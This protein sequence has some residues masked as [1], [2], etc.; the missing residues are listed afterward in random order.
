[1]YVVRVLYGPGEADKETDRENGNSSTDIPLYPGATVTTKVMLLLL[2]AFV[3]HHK[4]SK[5]VTNDLL[6]IFN[7]VLPKPNNCCIT[8]YKIRKLFLTLQLPTTFHY[9]CPTCIVS[10][11]YPAIK[12]CEICHISKIAKLFCLFVNI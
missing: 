8:V 6:Y 4:L 1:M 7:L 5:E 9:Y 3:I 12:V 11:N 2:L 10:I